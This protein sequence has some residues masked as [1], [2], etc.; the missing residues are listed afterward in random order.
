MAVIQV[1]ERSIEQRMDALQRA[2]DIRSRR[3][4]LKRD[5]RAGRKCAS[6][7]LTA[8]PAYIESMKV[9]ELLLAIP[10]YGR[11]KANK[12]LARIRISPSQTIGGMSDRQ[13]RELA[14][15]LPQRDRLRDLL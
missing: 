1:P 5:V 15:L 14:A 2:N 9:W 4:R 7:L 10:K 12:C 11:V 8:P 6:D 3:S 13:R